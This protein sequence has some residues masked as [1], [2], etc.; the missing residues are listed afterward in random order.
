MR[1]IWIKV[2]KDVKRG[3]FIVDCANIKAL[4]SLRAPSRD[5]FEEAVAAH[6]T[7]ENVGEFG[8]VVIVYPDMRVT[9]S[10]R[11]EVPQIDIV[12]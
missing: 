4:C 1:D 9:Y 7:N 6:V 5:G 2:A 12:H 11:S 3:G 8:D 10:A